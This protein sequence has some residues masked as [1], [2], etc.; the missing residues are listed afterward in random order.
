MP[1]CDRCETQMN[2]NDETTKL[3]EYV[4]P[5]CHRTKISRK[6]AYRVTA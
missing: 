1:E 2:H 3:T 5:H 4:C 6:A